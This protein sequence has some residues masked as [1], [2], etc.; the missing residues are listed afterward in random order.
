MLPRVS[1][2]KSAGSFTSTTSLPGVTQVT[3]DRGDTIVMRQIAFSADTQSIL[4]S[5]QADPFPRQVRRR[6]DAA[7]DVLVH[8]RLA[9]QTPRKNRHGMDGQSLIDRDQIR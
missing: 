4:I 2:F 7:V 5:A 6:I 8:L 3:V 1:I 9:E